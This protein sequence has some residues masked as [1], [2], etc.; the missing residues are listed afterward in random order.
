MAVWKNYSGESHG[1][2]GIEAFDLLQAGVSRSIR[3]QLVEFL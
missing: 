1:G 2:A 3:L